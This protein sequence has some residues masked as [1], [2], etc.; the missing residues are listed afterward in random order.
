LNIVRETQA[1]E[2]GVYYMET[3]PYTLAP[4]FNPDSCPPLSFNLN[5]A[6]KESSLVIHHEED[7]PPLPQQRQPDPEVVEMASNNAG[8][9]YV[10]DLGDDEEDK[11]RR[12]PSSHEISAEP[13]LEAEASL[14]PERRAGGVHEWSTEL[15]G[16]EPYSMTP[17]LTPTLTPQTPT[18][19]G[20]GSGSLTG[21]PLANED[22]DVYAAPLV[23]S[24]SDEG[25]DTSSTTTSA[26]SA[27]TTTAE[28]TMTVT[29]TPTQ[30]TKRSARVSPL[31]HR[32]DEHSEDPLQCNYECGGEE[33]EALQAEMQ[34]LRAEVRSFV[35]DR[36]LKRSYVS[37]AH[38]CAGRDRGF[39]LLACQRRNEEL[40]RENERLQRARDKDKG[41]LAMLHQ[42]LTSALNDHEE[43][44]RSG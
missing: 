37:C 29:P 34:L 38:V 44:E 25:K 41:L 33:L 17:T 1:E 22:V 18:K 4:A 19:H 32:E 36:L 35:F 43:V 40:E 13:L 20:S 21:E 9:D 3:L 12:T 39:Q 23:T 24:R 10:A 26:S 5:L 16:T 15:D 6:L 27:S 30:T 8:R 31:P 42:Q 7:V 11:D 2:E 14:Q 28:T